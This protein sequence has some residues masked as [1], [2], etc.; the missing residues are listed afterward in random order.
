M[1][2]LFGK[3]YL[4]VGDKDAPKV[5][6]YDGAGLTFTTTAAATTVIFGSKEVDAVAAYSTTTGAFV[7]HSD[8]YY[9]IDAQVTSDNQNK[10]LIYE[11]ATSIAVSVTAGADVSN[12]VHTMNYMSAGSTITLRYTNSAATTGTLTASEAASYMCVYK[13][14]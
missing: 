14:A 2:R 3:A 6:V 1:E 9:V 11:G 7:C 13:L 8:G 4:P 5:K 10:I 12:S